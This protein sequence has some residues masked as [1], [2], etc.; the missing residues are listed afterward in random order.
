MTQGVGYVKAR[1]V[2]SGNVIVCKEK[3]IVV[4]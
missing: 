4:C 1:A 3:T 2:G